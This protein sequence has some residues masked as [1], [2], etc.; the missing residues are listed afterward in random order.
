MSAVPLTAAEV[1]EALATL[2]G[3]HAEGDAAGA[4]ALA[5]GYRAADF[6]QALSF[7]NAIGA[8]AEVLE[9][10][11]E[12]WNCWATVKLR[13]NT[14]DAGGRVTIK[15]VALARAI[16]HAAAGMDVPLDVRH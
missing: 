6:A 15:D 14:H 9:H 12:I 2:P 1:E 10:H 4:T 8:A 5:A 7:I 16:A 13:L 3:W 11:P